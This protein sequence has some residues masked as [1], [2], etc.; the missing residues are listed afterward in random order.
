ME[1][2]EEKSQAWLASQHFAIL[3]LARPIAILI[4][5][6]CLPSS[7]GMKIP[8]TLKLIGISEMG[9]FKSVVRFALASQNLQQWLINAGVMKRA[10]LLSNARKE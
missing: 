3:I 10:L 4:L 7:V 1:E 2:E 6:R 9:K 8:F 5:A